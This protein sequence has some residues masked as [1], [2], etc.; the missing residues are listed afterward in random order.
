MSIAQSDADNNSSY[1]H[2]ESMGSEMEFPVQK[3]R[4]LKSKVK[5]KRNGYNNELYSMEN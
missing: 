5:K 4:V 2:S 1:D 3:M